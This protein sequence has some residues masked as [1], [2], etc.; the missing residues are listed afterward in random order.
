M[1][2][3]RPTETAKRN[4][5]LTRNTLLLTV[6]HASCVAQ[7]VHAQINNLI[8]RTKHSYVKGSGLFQ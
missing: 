6:K 8:A 7:Y 2:E 3:G 5:A 1:Q 4:S